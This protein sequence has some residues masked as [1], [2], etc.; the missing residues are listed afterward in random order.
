MPLTPAQRDAVAARGN[1]IVVA[2]AGTGKT[3]TLVERCVSVLAEGCSIENVL[4]VTFTDA[5]AAEMRHRLRERLSELATQANADARVSQWWQEQV[6]LLETARICTLHSFCLQ[7]IRE[8]FHLLGI[9]PAVKILDQDQVRPLLESALEAALKPHLEGADPESV[10]VRELIR[11]YGAGEPERIRRLMLQLHRYA[12]SLEAPAKWFDSQIQSL[13][14]SEPAQWREWLSACIR[15]WADDWLPRVESAS[16]AAENLKCCGAAL[17]QLRAESRE[18]VSAL[19]SEVLSADDDWPRGQKGRLR[20]P[21]EKLFEEA[22]FLASQFAPVGETDGLAADWTSVR[23][24]M[25]TLLQLAREFGASFTA[26]KREV[27]AID[28]ADLEQFALALL[29]YAEGRLTGVAETCRAQLEQ[30]FVDECQD[31]NAAQ[32]A[33]LRAVS[34][35]ATT[36]GVLAPSQANR[37]LVGDVKQSIYRF[38]M[39]RPELFTGYENA[40][41]ADAGAKRIVLGENF[42]SARAVIGFVNA[43]FAPLMRVDAGG[44]EYE[45]LIPGRADAEVAPLAAGQRGVEFHLIPKEAGVAGGE[46]D[47]ARDG[48]GLEDLLAVEREARLVALRLRELHRDGLQVWDKEHKCLRHVEWRDMAVLLR[49]PTGRVEAFAKEFHKCGVPLQAAR[50]GFFASTEILDLLSLLRLLDNPLQDIPL[51]AV[52]RSPL[53]GLTLDEIAEVR[54]RS[55]E[56]R[57]WTALQALRGNCAEEI[58]SLNRKVEAFVVAFETWREMSRQAS[59]SECVERALRDTGYEMVIEAGQRGSERAANVRKFVRMVREYDPFQ[60]QGLFRFLKFVDGLIAAEQDAEPAPA[61]TQNAVQLMSIH[62]SKGLE[63]PVVVAACLGTAFNLGDLH[64]EVLLDEHYG[65]CAKAVVSA[66]N[67]RHPTLAHWLAARRQKQLALAEEMRLLYVAATRARDRLI[68]TATATRKDTD[69]WEAT[70]VRT[71]SQEEMLRA[72][73][74]L[75]WL[76]LWLPTVTRAEDWRDDG[77]ANELLH[78]RIV[79]NAQDWDLPELAKAKGFAAMESQLAGVAES[80]PVIDDVVARVR[81]GYP[82]AAATEEPAK[83]NVTALRRRAEVLVDEEAADWSMGPR[84]GRVQARESD[85]GAAEVGTLYHRFLEL[86]SVEGAVDEPALAGQLAAMVEQGAFTRDEAAAL[87]LGP[88][89]RFWRGEIGRSIRSQQTQIRREVPFTARFSLAELTQVTGESFGADSEEE[90]VVV[91]GVADLVVVGE[92]ELWLLDFKTDQVQGAELADRVQ[93][94]RPQL[95]LYASALSAI[96]GKP[97][98]RCWIHFLRAETTVEV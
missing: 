65:V 54:I 5:A 35:D 62:Q 77:G 67:T 8:N 94:Y 33:I 20:E 53:V 97:A 45:P 25:R 39:A 42:R 32:D 16:S 1:V 90:F 10:A 40:W 50:G 6:A 11:L 36:S 88:V 29:W 43:L 26:A 89:V 34:R 92:R 64:R 98:S 82:N 93:R 79:R 85:L 47:E 72:R 66:S 73:C 86:M 75:D 69:G 96:F 80:G 70:P 78:W 44:V 83:S 55:R 95:R 56:R 15:E 28:F 12:Q 58:K 18:S 23:L 7:L 38:R 71:F 48:R 49:S 74:P 4:M 3:S 9:D 46:E 61:P 59:L 31:I 63:F 60:R 51:L 68:L 30:V 37:F 27:G 84:P 87:D 13:D 41:R 19:L 81:W 52:L 22:A 14:A 17:A 91:Q 21:V 57:L 2:G 76:L 24:P